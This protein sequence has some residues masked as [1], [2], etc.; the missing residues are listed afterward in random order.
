MRS[1]HNHLLQTAA[2]AAAA[3][4]L[5][6]TFRSSA[7][8]PVF[9]LPGIKTRICFLGY[10]MVKRS[11]P[12]IQSVVTLRSKDGT[13]LIRTTQLI[14]EAKAYRIELE[15]LLQ[16]ADKGDQAE[17]TG[18][19]EIEFFSS[20]DLVFPYPAVVVNYYGPEFG[21]V[22]HTAQRVYNDAEDRRTNEEALVSEAGFNLYADGDREPFFSFINGIEYVRNGRISM[23]FFNSR[24]QTMDFHIEVPLLAPYETTVI[25]PDRHTDLQGFLDGKPGTA[26]INF[27]VNWV[28]P[29]IVAG[30]LQ[31][32]KKAMSVTHTYYDCTARSGKED[33]WHE[34]QEGWHS[35]SMLIPVSVSGERL[36]HV[37]FYPIYSPCELE[38]DV[39][40]YDTDG[41]LLG[42]KNN[43]QTISPTDNRL[44]T[45]DIKA[46][47]RDLGV[48]R[49][50]KLS[51][52]LIARPVRSSRLPTRLKVGLDYGLND[53]SLTC[54]I[55]KTMDVF[56]PTLEHKKSSFHWAP[57]IADQEDGIVWIMNSSPKN[58]YVR[59]ASIN[60]TFYREQDT[61][62]I[63][64]QLFL[65]PNGTYCLRLSED[66]QL[67]AFFS[68]QIGWY[69]CVSDN[70][71]IKTY[72][73][74]EGSSGIV[75]GDHDF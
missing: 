74:C 43:A 60:L 49:D 25:Y 21:S 27:D 75:G 61:E 59:S 45:L 46:L 38:M 10:W 42:T 17:Y 26:R 3:L 2:P 32:S 40:L 31:H 35:A 65:M 55:C 58:P 73:L 24:K 69:T 51:A 41:N 39:E 19:L 63:V 71:Y 57:V 11:I 9:Q 33:Y 30:N 53:S 7:I 4:T 28:F 64:R 68:Y 50:Q 52:N 13:I 66:L 15:H 62:T 6:P 16:A 1:Y 47:C 72:Y 67:Q 37:N 48:S 70:P 34:P 18:S 8:F 36:T 23:K 56:N 44:Q 12:E 5:K 20:R 54:N 29:R 22:V 14:T